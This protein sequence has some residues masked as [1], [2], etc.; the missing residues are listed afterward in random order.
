M[1]TKILAAIVAVV[2][3]LAYLGPM[4]LKMKD[5]ALSVVVVIGVAVMLVDL[6]QSLGKPED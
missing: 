4:V 1:T 6:W 2:L 5:A 3:V